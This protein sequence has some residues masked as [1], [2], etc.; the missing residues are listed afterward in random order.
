VPQALVDLCA[1][2]GACRCWYISTFERIFHIS[3]LYGYR[4]LPP[5]H[6]HTHLLE[7]W[8]WVLL[9][10]S[11]SHVHTARGLHQTIQ[12]HAS[13]LLYAYTSLLILR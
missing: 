11:G 9:G 7:P 8:G 4:T 1:H 6:I 12:H 2:M 13:F 3:C 10:P 5:Q